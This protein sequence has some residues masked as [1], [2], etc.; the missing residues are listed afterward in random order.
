MSLFTRLFG[1]SKSAPQPRLSPRDE[2]LQ[3]LKSD[4]AAGLARLVESRDPELIMALVEFAAPLQRWRWVSLYQA[5]GALGEPIVPTLEQVIARGEQD[6]VEFAINALDKCRP[7]GLPALCRT[8]AP[9]NSDDVRGKAANALWSTCREM[10]ADALPAL[11]HLLQALDDQHGE[12]SYWSA[13]AIGEIGPAASSA[14]PRLLATVT[15]TSPDDCR[16][17]ASALTKLG[18][19]NPLLFHDC[20]KL[21]REVASRLCARAADDDPAVAAGFDRGCRLLLDW[22]RQITPVSYD[23]RLYLGTSLQLAEQIVAALTEI[24]VV[25]RHRIPPD[26]VAALLDLKDLESEGYMGEEMTGERA[27][28]EGTRV[29]TSELKSRLRT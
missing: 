26:V 24:A 29:S 27:W 8:L 18:Y 6:Q 21:P 4:E 25:A 19:N 1:K 3:L 13:E 28:R 5:L 7:A 23:G 9:P 14:I 17:H 22:Y 10:K 11:P 12:V 16:G 15:T 2:F 20:Y